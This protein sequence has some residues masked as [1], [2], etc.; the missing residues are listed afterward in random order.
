MTTTLINRAGGIF[1]ILFG[2]M[3]LTACGDMHHYDHYEYDTSPTNQ[4]IHTEPVH[5]YHHIPTPAPLAPII[6]NRHYLSVPSTSKTVPPASR[7]VPVILKT[8]PASSR[9]VPTLVAPQVAP[10]TIPQSPQGLRGWRSSVS[11]EQS[12]EPSRKTAPRSSSYSPVRS[13]SPSQSRSY[14]W[15]R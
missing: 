8:V 3:S 12:Q 10:H 11:H 6:I 7:S 1:G 14:S 5:I 9:T 13:S 4:I 15:R 2:I